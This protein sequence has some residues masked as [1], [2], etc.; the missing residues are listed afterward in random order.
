MAFL[1]NF[2]PAFCAVVVKNFENNMCDIQLEVEPSLVFLW[3]LRELSLEMVPISE[4][5][6][7]GAQTKT[8]AEVRCGQL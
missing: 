4:W 2:A 8:L 6:H 1:F 5:K 7:L 3:N